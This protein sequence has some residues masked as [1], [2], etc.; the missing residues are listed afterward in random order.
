MPPEGSSVVVIELAEWDR[1]GPTRDRRLAGLSL[2][3]D[4][5]VQRLVEVLRS[6][7]DIREGFEGLEIG[8]TSFVGRVDVGP[9]RIVVRPKLPL[10]PLTRLL[11]YAY[12][13]RDL[14]PPLDETRAPT[15]RHGLHDLLVALL[16]AEVEELLHRGLA[17]HYV[18]LVKV[19]GSPRGRILVPELVRQ[20]G[21][22]EAR[23]PCQ[24]VERRADWRLNRVLCAG[25]A[26]AG[27][28][29]GDRDL[30]W[31]VHRL[32]EGFSDVAPPARLT[33]KDLDNAEQDLTRLTATYAPAL[34][35]IRLLLD[36]QG[37]A[38]EQ[39]VGQV[40]RTPGF[41]F[42]MNAFFQRLLSRFLHE[43][44]PAELSVEDEQIARGVLGYAPDANPRRRTAPYLRPDFALFQGGVLQCFLDAKYRDVWDRGCP[45]EWLYQLS[46]YAL[47][48]PGH[49]G[50]VL[51]YA[52]MAADARD[53][54]VDVRPPS[55]RSDTALTSVVLRP[56]V[57][58][59]LADLVGPDI[60]D[61]RAAERCRLARELVSFKVRVNQNVQATSMV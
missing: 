53:E 22:R 7:V 47:A 52:S 16:A 15:A 10:M 35:I 61:R 51:L 14:G 33:T 60:S 55:L 9:L 57:L 23:L 19:L 46:L 44:L 59:R 32:S 50:S 41:L 5:P 8:S 2:A 18:P 6:R 12:G 11:R 17:R 37:L 26:L 25:L 38:F 21:V 45:T 24:Y 3:G 42:D 54:R 56:V 49:R 27:R 39:A 31:R 48:S 29:T 36:A 34:A 13:L 40:R 43:H 28:V 20:G 4:P 58:P 1:V 30:R